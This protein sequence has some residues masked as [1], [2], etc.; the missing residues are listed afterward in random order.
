MKRIT[1]VFSV[2]FSISL[3]AGNYV[4][5]QAHTKVGFEITHMM[6]STVEGQ[7][8]D[9]V[10][11]FE[12]D[13]KTNTLNKVEAKIQVASIDTENQKRDDHLR[14]EDFFDVKK[15][16]TMEFVS[17]EKLVIK[18]GEEKILKGKLTIKGITRNVDLKV[19]YVGSVKDPW[20]NERIG[21]EATTKINR[22][23]YNIT[24]NKLLEGGGLVVG[25][26]VTI[27][28]RGEGIKQK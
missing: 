23:D 18:P 5:D 10:A 19:R 26:E 25:D 14:S 13:E 24:W 2:L 17:N 3:W 22:R 21:F 7:F 27:R 9:Y 11:N 12:Y 8:K 20:G 28:I 16:P 15:F 1:F 6:I 4:I